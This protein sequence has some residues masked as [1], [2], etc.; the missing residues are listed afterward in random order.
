MRKI[1]ENTEMYSAQCESHPLDSITNGRL[2]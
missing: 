2:N 1:R